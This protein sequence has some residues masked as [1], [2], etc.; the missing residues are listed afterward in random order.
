M[1][2]TNGLIT[3]PDSYLGQ[4]IPVWRSG[5]SILIDDDSLVVGEGEEKRRIALKVTDVA[6]LR[7]FGR[8]Q[9]LKQIGNRLEESHNLPPET[10]FE[11]AKQLFLRLATDG[12]CHPAAPPPA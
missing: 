4:M 5:L 9:T 2:S 11:Y 7:D 10:G 8:D 6:V 3:L 12:L 1:F